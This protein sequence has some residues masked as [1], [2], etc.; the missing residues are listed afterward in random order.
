[1][2]FE[3]YKNCFK[4]DESKT[5]MNDD[6]PVTDTTINNETES[7]SHE[8]IQTFFKSL[9]TTKAETTSIKPGKSLKDTA[10]S[11]EEIDTEKSKENSSFVDQVRAKVNGLLKKE[12]DQNS[13][14][15]VQ[16]KPNSDNN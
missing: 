1:M 12:V 11:S 9:S 5:E 4:K 7:K 3:K 2:S 16:R 15:D 14:D 10:D 6:E 13:S 8:R